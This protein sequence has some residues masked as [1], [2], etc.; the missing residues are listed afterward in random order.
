MKVVSTESNL[1]FEHVDLERNVVLEVV[2]EEKNS[3]NFTDNVNNKSGDTEFIENQP[4]P[5]DYRD[6]ADTAVVQPDS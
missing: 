5:D 3:L 2:V 4:N 1:A 6:D